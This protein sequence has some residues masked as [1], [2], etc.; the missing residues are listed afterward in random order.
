MEL[1]S[2]GSASANSLSCDLFPTVSLG[3]CMTSDV[4]LLG[5]WSV[6]LNPKLVF[7]PEE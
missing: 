3:E 7:C 6:G 1:V 5:L 4:Y 2:D